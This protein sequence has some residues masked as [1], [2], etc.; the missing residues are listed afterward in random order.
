M[1]RYFLEFSYKGTNFNG[2]AHQTAGITRTVQACFNNMLSLLLRTQIS[3]TT[4]SRTDAGVHAQ[5]N[6]MHFDFDGEI[7]KNFIYKANCLL[8]LDISLKELHQVPNSA[9]SRFDA[10]SRTYLYS[11][12]TTKNPFINE[13][14]WFFPHPLNQSLMQEAAQIIL[15]TTHFDSFSKKHSD[16]KTNICKILKSEWVFEA[17][18]FYYT[19]CGDRFLRGMVRALVGTMIW[20]GSGKISLQDFKQ[21]IEDKDALKANFSTPA[22]GLCLM[23]VAYPNS[24][25][26][27]NKRV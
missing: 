11:C 23:H 18:N 24:L 19:V 5:N 10:I 21:L 17:E 14:S 7:I 4:S 25:F 12:H 22:H 6:F 3:T 26:L 1:A 2:L 20:V 9:H 15:H 8:P 13:T 16:A 27:P